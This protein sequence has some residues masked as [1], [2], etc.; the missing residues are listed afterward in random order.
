MPLQNQ[1]HDKKQILEQASIVA[2]G[3]QKHHIIQ[4]NS[5][6]RASPF[7]YPKEQSLLRRHF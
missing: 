1:W 4:I 6:Q 5:K 7:H 3:V 2:N